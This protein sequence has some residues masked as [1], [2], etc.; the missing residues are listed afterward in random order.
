MERKKGGRGRPG[1][2]PLTE[3][4]TEFVRLIGQG[5]SNA[6]I[7]P[8]SWMVSRCGFPVWDRGVLVV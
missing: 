6:V 2:A 5:V 3:K 1:G 7:P 8:E 4:R